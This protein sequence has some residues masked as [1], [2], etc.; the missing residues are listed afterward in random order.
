L[1]RKLARE[2]RCCGDKRGPTVR[3]RRMAGLAWARLLRE[4]TAA[5]TA[6]AL[7]TTGAWHN[8]NNTHWGG[9]V[10]EAVLAQHAVYM[11]V[12]VCAIHEH[13]TNTHSTPP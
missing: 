3:V 13:T 7:V 2:L 11:L 6:G 4:G 8:T 9:G 12:C 5:R 1:G 10:R